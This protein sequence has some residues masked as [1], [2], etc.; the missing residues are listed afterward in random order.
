MV[1]L[2]ALVGAFER[3]RLGV[4]ASA[5]KTPFRKGPA[6]YVA[7]LALFT[8]LLSGCGGGGT[9]SD[10]ESNNSPPPPPPPPQNHFAIATY[11][12]DNSRSG[13][14]SQESKL[15]PANV[16]VVSFGRLAAVPVQ[17]AIF[18]QPL[19]IADVTLSDGKNHNLVI[20]VTEH[21][22]VYAIDDSSYQ[23][24]WNRSLLDSQ[25]L[26]TPGSGAD[27]PCGESFNP[28]VGI[29]GTPVIDSSS[30]TVYLVAVT[31]DSQGQYYQT[32][33]ALRLTDGQ[34]AS[35]PTVITTPSGSQYG[36]ATFDPLMSFQRAALLLEN[37]NVYVPWA[38]QCEEHAGWLMSFSAT[39]LQVTAAWTPDPSGLLGGIWMGGGGPS[40]DSSGNIFLSVANGWSDAQT[41]GA[42]YGDSVVRL[43][44]QGNQIEVADYFMPYDYDK[45][46]NEDLDLGSGTPLL[47]PTQSGAAHPN[48]LI[49]GGKEGTI[50]LL[51]RDNLGKYHPDNDDQIL[52]SFSIQS[53]GVFNA[54]IFWNSTLY[55]G[56]T[57]LPVQAF[58]YD[59]ATQ[60]INTTPL[61]GSPTNMAYPG[62]S[63]SL[64][65][66]NGSAA[67][68]WAVETP[69]TNAI[70]RA[71]DPTNLST[72][73]Y[74]SEMSSDRDHAGPALRFSVPT[75]ADGEVFVGTQDEL[76]I[77]GE[78][79]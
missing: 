25:G 29:T 37:G 31:K 36:S 46:Y 2:E 54:P 10:G 32:L 17:G 35:T 64:T 33:Y 18:A 74:N 49:T 72:E 16:N 67:V 7:V 28:E 50:Y 60:M 66:N 26:I 38:S 15:T 63:P 61:S 8:L 3:A 55:Y 39:T 48:L 42:N 11:H 41:G 62:V 21:D 65:T 70:L 30:A 76:D 4:V 19:Y 53:T 13:I 71:Y 58:A 27:F 69:S 73:L 59:S 24:M 14:N 23:V 68:L 12:N 56:L 5:L 57:N 1:F 52:Q 43:N 6:A 22:Q 77:Y 47:L 75:V 40:A 51:N 45:L 79:P 20:V 78:L 44:P 9:V 34:N